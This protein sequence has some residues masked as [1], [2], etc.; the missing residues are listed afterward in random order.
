[1][2]KMPDRPRIKFTNGKPLLNKVKIEQKN[3]STVEIIENG[4]L[5][6][7]RKIMDI[8]Y[9]EKVYLKE[10]KARKMLDSSILLKF[11]ISMVNQLGFFKR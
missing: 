11:K 4:L 10:V 7:D 3:D 8:K 1:M 2:Q 5:F 9:I 6:T